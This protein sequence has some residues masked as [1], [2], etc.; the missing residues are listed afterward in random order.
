MNYGL[1]FRIYDI[2]LSFFNKILY[3]NNIIYL[4]KLKYQPVKFHLFVGKI[5]LL[6]ASWSVPGELSI[7]SEKNNRLYSYFLISL[8]IN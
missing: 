1:V 4:E 8:V 6:I 3:L 7:H 2:L 5:D